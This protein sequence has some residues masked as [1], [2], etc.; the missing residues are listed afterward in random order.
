MRR[1]DAFGKTVSGPTLNSMWGTHGARPAATAVSKGTIYFESDTGC[2]FYSD[3]AAW[4]GPIN[5]GAQLDYAQVT[6]NSGNITATTE[7]T[8]V[9]WITG[10]SVTYDGTPVKI[11]FFCAGYG[12]S[13]SFGTP[14]LV[15]LRDAT[16]LGRLNA[17]PGNTISVPQPMF[18]TAYD[19]PGVGAHVYKVAVYG[20]GTPGY[21]YMTAGAGGAGA[22]SP[23][24]LRVTKA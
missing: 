12:T 16:V 18:A 4:V 7:G 8:A 2:A 10:N 20:V 19:T 14:T 21:L 15:L 1:L 24:S 22:T 9:A 13:G 3:G 6:S 5:A 23:S 11:E 17:I